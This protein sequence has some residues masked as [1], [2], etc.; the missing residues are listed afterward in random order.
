[1]EEIRVRADASVSIY[2]PS[3]FLHLPHWQQRQLR[4]SRWSIKNVQ[5]LHLHYSSTSEGIRRG[6]LGP[7]RVEFGG[8]GLTC[9]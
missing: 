9:D 3:G 2:P 6:H 8:G 5:A 1:M 7:G 4:K